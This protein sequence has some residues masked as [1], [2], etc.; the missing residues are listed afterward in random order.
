MQ[1]RLD[2]PDDAYERLH[3]TLVSMLPKD[4]YP[5]PVPEPTEEYPM[6]E[7]KMRVMERRWEQGCQ[8][9]NY[10]DAGTE[11]FFHSGVLVTT[12]PSNGSLIRLD[13]ISQGCHRKE[14]PAHDSDD[15]D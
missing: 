1:R 10:K 5:L 12:D 14:E 3:F 11:D 13:T 8:I 2:S 7:A 9:F 6:T 4:F 15:D